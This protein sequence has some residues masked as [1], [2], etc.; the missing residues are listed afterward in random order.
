MKKIGRFF[1][2]IVSILILNSS[3]ANAQGTPGIPGTSCNTAGAFCSDD[4][5]YT[6]PAGVGSG[7]FGSNIGCLYST[8]NPAWYVMQVGQAGRLNI[9]MYTTPSHDIDFA[10]WGPFTSA[11]AGCGSLLTSCGGC[12]SHSSDNGPNPSNLGG[13]PVG[14]LVD[15]SYS[16]LSEEYVHIPNCVP[17]Q[18]Y[19]LLVTNYSNTACTINIG[20]DPTSTG[21]TN[22]GIMTPPPIGDTV[23][24]GET[25]NLHVSNPVAGAVYTW[26]G[27]NDFYVAGPSSTVTIPNATV[28]D[29]GQYSVS[30][31]LNGQVGDPIF[32]TVLV[33]PKP[34]LVLTSDTICTG[35]Q[36][37]ITAS[38]ASTYYWNTGATSPTLTVSPSITTQYKVTGTSSWGC[39]DSAT[40]QVVVFTNPTVVVTPNVVCNGETAIAAIPNALTFEWS[41]GIHTSDTITPYVTTEQI[42]T[43]TV[44]MAGGCSGTGTLTAKPN[45]TVTATG[46]EVCAGESASIS[47]TGASSYLWSNQLTGDVISVYPPSTTTYSVIGTDLFGC[48]GYD[49]ISVVV[50][51]KPTADFSP[52]PSVVTIDSPTITFTDLSTDATIWSW[53]F[54]DFKNLDNSSTDQNPTHDYSAVG[55]FKVWEVVST[56]FGCMDSTFRM[57][58]VEAPFYFYIPDAFTPDSDGKNETFCVFGRG[59]DLNNYS[60]EVYD[61]WGTLF[62]KTNSPT[63]C[64][65]GKING[66]KAP[67]GSYVYKINLKDMEYRFHEYLGRF[68]LLR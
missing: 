31:A 44:T 52:N 59:L 20:S 12:S 39:K 53:N 3:I 56:E 64:W 17:G 48:K 34:T 8:P 19:V 68:I 35:L 33:N 22:C 25:I 16:Y 9:H 66:E 50:H 29:G 11:T 45:P 4:P 57:V 60:L 32:C 63:V 41:D 51:P 18:W 2:I 38:G 5:Q 40:T 61:R 55:Y 36:A 24:V 27:P 23:C 28:A 49:T 58:Q 6:F 62:F 54:G 7:S 26:E 13:Y 67:A 42:Y 14:N 37:S 30:I 47:A 1:L 10:C 43:V 21:A 15:C 65:D 46:D